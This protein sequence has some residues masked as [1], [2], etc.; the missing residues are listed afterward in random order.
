MGKGVGL[1]EACLNTFGLARGPRELIPSGIWAP[2]ARSTQGGKGG[3]CTFWP[4]LGQQ[5][6][7]NQE[8]IRIC[9]PWGKELA[10][11]KHV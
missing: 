2:K 3:V 1:A 10:L 9:R 5:K 6:G 8:V 7:Q 11:Q 4:I